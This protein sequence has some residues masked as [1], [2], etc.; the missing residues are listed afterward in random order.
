MKEIEVVE[1]P[2]KSRIPSRQE[3]VQ[4]KEERHK[5]K[6][7]KRSSPKNHSREEQQADV[8]WRRRFSATKS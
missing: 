4:E 1:V 7:E 6:E 2:L 8:D 5:K 3:E